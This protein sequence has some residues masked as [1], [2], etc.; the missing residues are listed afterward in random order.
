MPP[1]PSVPIPWRHRLSTQVLLISGLLFLASA[2]AYG[3]LEWAMR[4]ALM[5]QALSGATLFGE[6]VA[7]ATR[8]AM[9]EDRRADAYEIMGTIGRQ[10]GIERVRVFN[11]DGR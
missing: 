3:V 8:R 11:K 4:Q 2:L 1:S 9:L 7:S 10:P 6:T 5:E